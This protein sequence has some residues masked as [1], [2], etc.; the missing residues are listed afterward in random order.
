MVGRIAYML[1]AG[2]SLM[3]RNHK[4]NN[5]TLSHITISILYPYSNYTKYWHTFWDFRFGNCFTFN[6]GISDFGESQK[7]L[8]S[9]NTGPAGGNVRSVV[10]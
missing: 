7:V 4:P 3:S 6:G 5:L 8:H 2:H 10:Y 1:P 9:F